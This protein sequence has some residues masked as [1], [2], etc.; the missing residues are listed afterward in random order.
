MHYW[1]EGG[2]VHYWCEG[3][4]MNTVLLLWTGCAER[5]RERE[6]GMRVC[7]W[8]CACTHVGFSPWRGHA[9]GAA[10]HVVRA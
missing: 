8:V 7:V 5:R 10:N 6:S 4:C 1:C 9:V 3:G 2:C